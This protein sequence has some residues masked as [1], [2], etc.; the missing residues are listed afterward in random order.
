MLG[1]PG[2]SLQTFPEATLAVANSLGLPL[3]T[4]SAD[5]AAWARVNEE[6]RLCEPSSRSGRSSTSTGSSTVCRPGSPTPP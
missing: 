3:L 6:L 5:T 2:H 1:T 4:T